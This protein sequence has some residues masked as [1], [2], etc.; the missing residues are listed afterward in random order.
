MTASFTYRIQEAFETV[1]SGVDDHVVEVPL[2]R[3]V[4]NFD[5]GLGTCFS[6]MDLHTVQWWIQY[7]IV[8][9]EQPWWWEK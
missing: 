2:L 3:L 7:E 8:Q 5:E 4:E 6:D 1:A 9:L